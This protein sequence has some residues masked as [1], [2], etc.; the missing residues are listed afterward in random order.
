MRKIGIYGFILMFVCSLVLV[1][2]TKSYASAY[3]LGANET[4]LS[5]RTLPNGEVQVFTNKDNETYLKS[6]LLSSGNW[7]LKDSNKL[8]LHKSGLIPKGTAPQTDSNLSKALKA[9][10]EASGINLSVLPSSVDY[11]ASPYLPPVGDQ[12]VNDCAAWSAGYYLRTYQEAKDLGWDVKQNGLPINSHVFSPSFIYNQ[13]NGGGDNGSALEDVGGLLETEGAATLADFPYVTGDYL[14]QPSLTTV[15]TAYPHRIKQ[16]GYLFTTN[17]APDIRIQQM[18]EYLNTGDLPVIGVNA[19]FNYEYPEVYN[20]NNF[21]TYDTSYIG[22]HGLAV[23]GYNDDIQTPD[24]KGAFKVIN[25]WGTQWGD[26]GFGY[27]TYQE[28]IQSAFEGFIFT[29]LVNGRTVDTLDPTSINTK[30]IS[31]TQVQYSWTAPL[32]ATGYKL[33]DESLN[34]IASPTTPQYT[35]NL[36]QSGVYTRYIQ[37][38]NSISADDPV[39]VMV[40]STSSINSVNT[41]QLPVN[42]QNDVQFD[43]QFNGSG[44]YNFSI[45]DSSGNVVDTSSNLQTTGGMTSVLW[46]GNDSLGRPVSNG[47]YSVEI[48][49]SQSGQT[50]YTQTVNKQAKVSAATAELNQQNGVIQSV[51]VHLTS[52]LDGNARIDVINGGVKT[53]LATG[54]TLKA[55]QNFDYTIPQN[56]FDFNQ[57]DLANVTLELN[58]Q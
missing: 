20:G 58:V 13:I 18:K 36:S 49:S 55:G 19:G 37:A 22:G 43:I 3:P 35:E 57:V 28:F 2:P 33:F 5:Q 24:G 23:V 50:L 40:D 12:T 42:I 54:Q 21:V 11:S 52:A 17:D 45:L 46:A 25:S 9:K 32:N 15:Q 29:D 51:S 34:L 47:Q 44:T 48:I 1:Y 16:W 41:K 53:E 38:Y 39:K 7:I 4:I 30:V 6:F 56:V 10:L 31:P 14:T 8:T 26:Y 27:I